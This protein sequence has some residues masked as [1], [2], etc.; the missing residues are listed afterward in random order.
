MTGAFGGGTAM[1]SH[2]ADRAY[3]W[4]TAALVATFVAFLGNARVC[5]AVGTLRSGLEPQ[6]AAKSPADIVHDGCGRVADGILK[7]G[8]IEGDH[9]GDVDD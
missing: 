1:H 5:A 9:G 2:A 4:I 8:L 6:H 7:V 3:I